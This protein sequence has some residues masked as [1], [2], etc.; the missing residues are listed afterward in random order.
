MLA[1]DH[2]PANHLHRI[3]RILNGLSGLDSGFPVNL[4]GTDIAPRDV[5]ETQKETSDPHRQGIE[6]SGL[7]R[8]IIAD[9]Q[10]EGG[11]QI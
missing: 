9:N 11:H 1:V 2:A 6:K 5:G 3:I 4:V 10:I 7:A 8:G